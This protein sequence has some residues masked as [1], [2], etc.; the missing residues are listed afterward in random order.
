MALQQ[1]WFHWDI[2][3]VHTAAIIKELMAAKGIQLLE[4]LPYLPDLAPADFLFRRVKEA[5]VGIMLDR[6][7]LKNT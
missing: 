3:P 1:W 6:E 7:S 2:A 4:H 5:L